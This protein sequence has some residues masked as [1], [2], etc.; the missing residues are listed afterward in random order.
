MQCEYCEDDAVFVCSDCE[1]GLCW[2]HARLK[3][4][5]LDCVP[6]HEDIEIKIRTGSV[7]DKAFLEKFKRTLLLSDSE[8]EDHI[9]NPNKFVFIAEVN[10]TPIGFAVLAK[11]S[12]IEGWL[13]VIGVLPHFQRMGVGTKLMG[14][15]INKSRE[16]GLK[17]IN[18]TTSNENVPALMLFMKRGFKV[19]EAKQ[20]VYKEYG[21][22]GF[23]VPGFD[24][25][26]LQ[27][28]LYTGK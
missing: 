11:I 2:N 15:I 18:V 23:G 14:A 16:F 3:V 13:S 22:Y 21:I 25:L 24:E 9:S 17:R 10:N 4:V 20:D 5:C 19:V 26:R 8:I 28:S 1:K 27:L 6:K 12:E 7:K